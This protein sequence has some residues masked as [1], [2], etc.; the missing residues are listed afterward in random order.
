MMDC[1]AVCL[2]SATL[3]EHKSQFHHPL[4]GLCADICEA[5]AKSCEGLAGMEDCIEA[6]RACAAACRAME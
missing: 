4:C 3:M 6:C 5:C 2:A 1:A